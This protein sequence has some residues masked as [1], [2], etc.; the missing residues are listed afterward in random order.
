M[1]FL[2]YFI[3]IFVA[4]ISD[5]L[6][7]VTYYFDDNYLDIFSEKQCVNANQWSLVSYE[8]YKVVPPYEGRSEAIRALGNS[9]VS[10]F[11]ILFLEG[12][13]EVTAYLRTVSQYSGITVTVFDEQDEVTT[14]VKYEGMNK[15]LVPGWVNVTVPIK[16][17]TLGYVQIYGKSLNT[18]LVLVDSL[19][20]IPGNFTYSQS[21]ITDPRI[22]SGIKNAPHANTE[23]LS[24]SDE[25]IFAFDEVY[26]DGDLID[27]SGEPDNT[28]GPDTGA[29]TEEPSPGDREDPE[30]NGF[31]NPFTITIVSV[32]AFTVVGLVGVGAYYLGKS[33]G[34][35]PD[36]PLDVETQEAPSIIP[37]A[38]SVFS[39][40][41]YD[42]YS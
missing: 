37:R 14:S 29:S 40:V 13:L 11:P 17:H 19:Q 15:N 3:T 5:D 25:F 36:L 41:P 33:R 30:N 2:V 22:A 23:E 9:C 38:R 32:G 20:Y 7:G 1:L 34:V 16:V 4:V 18:E 39:E 6:V 21:D 28:E 42:R 35:S 31:W 26:T 12:T 10:S 8:H 24:D 27:G